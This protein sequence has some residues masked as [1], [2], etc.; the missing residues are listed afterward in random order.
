MR[1]TDT[2]Y[3]CVPTVRVKAFLE[4]YAADTYGT[5]DRWAR[6][7]KD[8]GINERRLYGI[9]QELNPNVTFSLFDKILTGL[10]MLHV[11][12]AEPEDGGFADYY[13]SDIPPAPAEPSVAQARNGFEESVRRCHAVMNKG[14]S[15]LDHIHGR[16]LE[17][18]VAA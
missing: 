17:E 5:E 9:R 4:Q 16:A 11:W 2:Q 1:E 6:L 7:A 12:Y 8:S 3:R 13:L 15:V 10:D 18:N 14:V